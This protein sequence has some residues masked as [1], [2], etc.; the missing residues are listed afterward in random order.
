MTTAG[1]GLG[2]APGLGA[3]PAL[4]G[5]NR[6]MDLLGGG[7]GGAG[8]FQ[9]PA[10]S[11]PVT[12]GRSPSASFSGP[13]GGAGMGAAPLA[14]PQFAAAPTPAEWTM[15]DAERGQ[16]LAL[17]SQA[18]QDGDGLVGGKEA[19]LFF[20]QSGLDN[21]TLKQIWLLSDVDKDNKL[22]PDEF[23]IA[24][25][26]TLRVRKKQ[27]LPTTL[28]QSM[29][30]RNKQAPMM[31][32]NSG[33]MGFDSMQPPPQQQQPSQGD[34]SMSGKRALNLDLMGE[35]L[36]QAAPAPLP[37]LQAQSQ[38][39]TLQHPA[40][41]DFMSFGG[42]ASDV[43]TLPGSRGASKPASRRTSMD[44]GGFG[45]AP[46]PQQLQQQ[47]SQ[48]GAQA[49][50]L[51]KQQSF[52][53]SSLMLNTAT[54]SNAGMQQPQQAQPG[55]MSF[56]AAATPAADP[57]KPN[58][59][60]IDATQAYEDRSTQLQILQAQ[61][62]AGRG[63]AAAADARLQ[64]K[65]AAV[66]QIEAQV[67]AQ[68][69]L[70]DEQR[71]HVA[72][73]EAQSTEAVARAA[74]AKRRLAEA[75]DL[76]RNGETRKRELQ[77]SVSQ[78]KRETAELDSQLSLL[79]SQLTSLRSSL[80]SM[81]DLKSNQASIV[82]ARRDQQNRLLHEKRELQDMVDACKLELA[83]MKAEADL[84]KQNLKTHQEGVD[85]M[86]TIL[87][88]HKDIVNQER[89]KPSPRAEAFVLVNK[90]GGGAGN[91][92]SPQS[93]SSTQDLSPGAGVQQRQSPMQSQSLGAMSS[94]SSYPD[95]SPA[96]AKEAAQKFF[97]SDDDA[98][99]TDD[100]DLPSLGAPA[101]SPAQAPATVVLTPSPPAPNPFAAPAPVA[102]SP[103][104]VLSPVPPPEPKQF[105]TTPVIV[106]PVGAPKVAT[107]AAEWN[108]RSR[109]ASQSGDWTKP[110]AGAAHGSGATHGS[111]NSLM[112]DELKPTPLPPA[113]TTPATVSSSPNPALP[114]PVSTSNISPQ[115]G[116]GA[117]LL[118]PDGSVSSL[119]SPPAP[120]PPNF[121]QALQ[122]TGVPDFADVGSPGSGGADSGNP[123]DDD[124]VSDDPF[125]AP[126]PIAAAT[127]TAPSVASPRAASIFGEEDDPFGPSS[128]DPFSA[129]PAPA[130]AAPAA[131]AP[132]P[133]AASSA[134]SPAAAAAVPAPTADAFGAFDDF[135]AFGS[136]PAAAPAPAAAAPTPVAAAPAP[137]AAPTPVAATAASPAAAAPAPTSAKASVAASFDAAMAE[138]WAAF[139]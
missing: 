54:P 128:G 100:I 88:E 76:L 57:S 40:Q 94:S 22:N 17:F 21:A 136:A 85:A 79:D 122:G 39:Q 47:Q 118:S 68:Q 42:G 24:M 81:E 111:S 114:P 20:K 133:A 116:S 37:S 127:N 9:Q 52:G 25:H 73:M 50:G 28:P 139:D 96:K 90:P 30:P 1:P 131:A 135:D 99:R 35:I 53:F 56:G 107:I 60:L 13:S 5:A 64:E 55:L 134:P 91:Q 44:A 11:F 6:G 74:D 63:P 125:G 51:Q 70:L 86:H 92:Q 8:G 27:P 120:A 41:Q 104:A 69:A 23:S 89:L 48:P 132:S 43:S 66:Q 117:D 49:P 10:A 78:A 129:A 65:L 3:G 119:V 33:L 71:R 77:D 121:P 15:T 138:D 87:D 137:A 38:Q 18:D 93:Q 75:Q 67:A 7:G 82:Q 26:L 45:F 110:A 98:F 106:T 72:E 4:G 105:G 84:M 34:L 97:Q 123:W 83:R 80:K 19:N 108:T 61:T 14:S 62:E 115:N 103:A 102:T 16:Y 12:L 95:S 130:A 31:P 113:P 126:E 112:H 46:P 32:Q 2:N 29:L 101:A 59:A 124:P 58:Y 109:N 36:P